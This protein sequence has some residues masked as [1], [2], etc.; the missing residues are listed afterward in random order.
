MILKETNFDHHL[1]KKVCSVIFGAPI[2]SLKQVPSLRLP[3]NYPC[4]E[5]KL[6]PYSLEITEVMLA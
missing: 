3:F 5:I 6:N 2:R 4:K 1:L